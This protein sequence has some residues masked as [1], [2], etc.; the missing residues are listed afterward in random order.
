MD[1]TRYRQAE[2][3]LWESF[4]LAPT[5]RRVRLERSGVTVRAQEVGE[6]PPV[7][8]VHGASNGGTSWASLVARLDGFRCL[9]LDRPGCGLSDPLPTRL[10]D[11]PT[12]AAFADDLV[13]DVLDA[14]EIDRAQVIATSMGGYYGFRA[15]AA[16]PER[17]AG[18]VEFGWSLGSP[19]ER[20]TMAFRLATV[21][22]LGRV[23]AEIP[24]TKGAVRAMLR[25]IGLRAAI[26]SGRF[27]DQMVDWYV[28]LLRDTDTMRNEMTAY[29]RIMR[30]VRGM[31]EAVILPASLL[32][33]IDAP[34][35]VL[36]GSEDP[37]GGAETARRFV[38]PIP[39]VELEMMPGGHAVWIDDPDR[40]ATFTRSVLRA[41]TDP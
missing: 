31:D 14:L 8:L 2:Q 38:E 33:Q 30:P 23:M 40:A 25:N 17:V 35:G 3:R 9:L 32:E 41:T 18:L 39:H 34:V 10:A 36:W 37:N 20:L 16:H 21:P 11:I 22:G 15:A 26:D 13:V 29:P 27:T 5:S 28:A 7:L 19:M 1:E 4:D 24:P 6:G 12:L